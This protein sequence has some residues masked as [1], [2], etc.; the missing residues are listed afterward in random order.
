MSANLRITLPDFE[1][2]NVESTAEAV[3]ISAVSIKVAP[4]CPDCGQVGRRVHSW[5]TA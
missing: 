2:E 5:Y 4:R 3:C 1:V